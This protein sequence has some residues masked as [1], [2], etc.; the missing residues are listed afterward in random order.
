VTYARATSMGK[1]PRAALH[2]A[3]RALQ[4]S[5]AHAGQA[6]SR[7]CCSRVLSCLLQRGKVPGTDMLPAHAEAAPVRHE[8][9][10]PLAECECSQN[11]LAEWECR[12]SG[13][14]VCVCQLDIALAIG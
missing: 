2:G 13:L 11:S 4:H 7:V 14:P 6:A 3:R 10:G 8:G 12:G 9:G 5:T 1:W